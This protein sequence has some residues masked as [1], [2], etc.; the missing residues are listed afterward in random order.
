MKKLAL[1]LTLAIVFI[2]CEGPQGP[3]GFDGLNGRNGDD[4]IAQ[5]YEIQRS[6]FAP[7]YRFRENHPLNVTVFETDM[8]L[9][10]IAWEEVIASDGLPTDVWRLLPQTVYS[11]FGEFAYNY[12][13]T[14]EY[15]DIFIDGPLTT[16]F[17]LLSPADTDNQIFR[18]VILPAGIAQNPLL[19]ITDYNSVMNLGGLTTQDIIIIE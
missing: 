1:L 15:I 8:I 19:D 7:D 13:S 4:F 12:E 14:F 5:S 10:Y 3:P 18:V 2:S 9:V 17:N 6:F 11:D 16:D